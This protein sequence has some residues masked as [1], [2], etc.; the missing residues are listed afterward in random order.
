ML[1]KLKKSKKSFGNVFFLKNKVNFDKQTCQKANRIFDST[2]CR[3]FRFW[4]E[5]K[6]M[7]I[8][9]ELCNQIC[10]TFCTT[11]MKCVFGRNFIIIEIL[12]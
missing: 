11:C 6:H 1:K 9:M 2:F 3:I 4:R 12:F 10:G 8:R 5:G 7:Y